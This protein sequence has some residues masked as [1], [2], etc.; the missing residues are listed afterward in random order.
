MTSKSG[1]HMM[2]TPRTYVSLLNELLMRFR[3]SL[4]RSSGEFL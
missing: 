2:V 1:K 3:R 4:I